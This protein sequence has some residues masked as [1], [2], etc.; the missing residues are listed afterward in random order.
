MVFFVLFCFV[1]QSCSILLPRL[2]CNGAILAHCNVHLPGSSNSPDSASRV[3]GIIGICYHVQLSFYVFSRDE[4][5]CHVG[6]AGLKLLASSNSLAL[7]PQSAGIIDMSHHAWLYFV[8]YFI[9]LF[10]FFCL[11]LCFLN[12]SWGHP[13]KGFA[14]RIRKQ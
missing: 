14:N 9:F 2:E 13:L 1:R 7:A 6:Q 3:A 5:F 8:S 12:A 10:L 4:V 11:L